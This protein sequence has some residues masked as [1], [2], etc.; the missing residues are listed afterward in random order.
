MTIKCIA[1]DDE[2][3]AL[4]Q[5]S[6]YIK[7]TPILE[8]LGGF[9]NGLEAVEIIESQAVELMFVDIDMPGIN[10]V[11]LVKSLLHKPLV[12]FTTAYSE[13]AVEGFKVD[14]ID[15]LL[16]PISYPNF[17]KAANKAIRMK[18]YVAPGVVEFKINHEFLFVKSEYRLVRINFQ[19]IK[20]IE[21]QHEYIR[22]NQTDGSNIQT[23]MSLK[24]IEPLLPEQFMRIHRSFIVNTNKIQIVERNTIVFENNVRIPV[25]DQYKEKFQEFLKEGFR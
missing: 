21:S 10:G 2:P 1:I 13:Y 3:L 7:R 24:S 17:I 20:Y 22:I 16:K 4:A 23:L 12:V 19:D 9:E 8:F 5:L 14:A 6:E 11:D 25:G 18:G 15:Y